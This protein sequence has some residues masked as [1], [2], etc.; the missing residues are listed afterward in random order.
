[1]DRLLA[2][3]PFE[4]ALFTEAGLDAV[5]V[6]HPLFEHLE[7]TVPAAADRSRGEPV[8]IGLLPGSRR[9]E[10][11]TLLPAMLRAV[12]RVVAPREGLRL[13]LPC[14][15]KRVRAEIDRVLG[16]EAGGLEIRVVEGRTHEEMREMD[17]ALVA[18]GTACLELAYYGVPMVVMYRVSRLGALL[19]RFILI[20]PHVALVNVVAGRRVVPELVRAGDLAPAAA[21]ALERWLGS[22]AER[23]RT[24]RELATVRAGLL[25]EG[26]SRRAAGWV[27]DLPSTGR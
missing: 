15:G 24:R 12:R 11:R 16:R 9:S 26:V 22:A 27:L 25:A 2:I 20:T 23:E 6:G 18:S 10:V 7:S 21:E 5:F 17:L 4:R 14:R 13:V 19:K 3:L 8:V 1:V